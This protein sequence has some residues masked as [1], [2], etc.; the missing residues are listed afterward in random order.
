MPEKMKMEHKPKYLHVEVAGAFDFQRAKDFFDTIVAECT[1]RKQSKV[2]IDGRKMEGE[3]S[4]VNR[5][6]LGKYLARARTQAIRFA[7]VGT[8]EVL[9]SDR[10]LETV[11]SNLGAIALVT[12]DIDKALQWLGVSDKSA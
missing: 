10:F 4:V 7:I 2:L 12:T 3:L 5:Y 11:A 8:E 6:E 1:K 9:L